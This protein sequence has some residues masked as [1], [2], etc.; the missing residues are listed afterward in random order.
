[1]LKKDLY[2]F[3]KTILR[4][5]YKSRKKID[6][7][8]G[9]EVE[10]PPKM[11]VS[12]R[13][14][15]T[16]KSANFQMAGRAIGWNTVDKQV[17]D[18]IMSVADT[19]NPQDDL[20]VWCRAQARRFYHEVSKEVGFRQVY[21]SLMLYHSPLEKTAAKAAPAP[22]SA[23]LRLEGDASLASVFVADGQMTDAEQRM[24]R[25]QLNKVLFCEH[26]RWWSA[27]VAEARE[28]MQ[29]GAPTASDRFSYHCARIISRKTGLRDDVI[30]PVVAAWLIEKA[31]V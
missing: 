18:F 8:G 27:F 10:S 7:V 16:T 17:V 11:P 14:S 3:F 28:D 9:G 25:A 15:P 21:D 19:Y 29:S 31:G 23:S 30:A 20:K 2:L 22:A 26:T 13:R 12:T 6:C 5:L 4:V 24:G 1:M